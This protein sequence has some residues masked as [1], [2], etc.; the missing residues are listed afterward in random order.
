[1]PTHLGQSRFTAAVIGLGRVGQGYDY[2]EP[3]GV[4]IQTHASAYHLHD[5][6]DLVAG[7]DCN[8]VERER[9]ERKF[10]RPA[11]ADVGDMLSRCHPDVVSIA[12]PTLNHTE[13]LSRALEARPLAVLCEKPIA[14][15]RTA[16]ERMVTLAAERGSVLAVNYIRRFDPGVLEMRRALQEGVL[17]DVVKG[18]AW[19]TKGLRHNG[20]HFVDLLRFWLGEATE[21]RVT[22][23]GRDLDGD[24]EPDVCIGF[25]QSRVYVLAARG[26]C[27]FM[28]RVALVGT[29]G[30]VSYGESGVIEIRRAARNPRRPDERRLS[31]EP[32]II[33]TDAARYQW[34]VVDA[35]YRHLTNGAELTSDGRS[36]TETLGVVETALEER[37]RW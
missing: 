23:P 17:G 20:S 28:G 15:C 26:E 6:Y 19:Y 21:I 12:V 14:E 36:A 1:M 10:A 22:D 11:F 30:T 37:K 7:V 18:T 35:L 2:S 27:F 9:F 8:P 13:L 5:G 29:L 3:G 32:E 31:G 25:G 16:A 34:H 24:A 33:P 4:R